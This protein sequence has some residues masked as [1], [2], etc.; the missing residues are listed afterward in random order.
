MWLDELAS[1][2]NIESR[3]Y[4]DLATQSLDFNQVAPIGFLLSQKLMIY[5]G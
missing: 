3:N 5:R 1:A 2:K 4:Y